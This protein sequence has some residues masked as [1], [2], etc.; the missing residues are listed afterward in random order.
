MLARTPP[1]LDVGAYGGGGQMFLTDILGAHIKHS[2][3]SSAYENLAHKNKKKKF[4]FMTSYH[5]TSQHLTN[6]PNL[7]FR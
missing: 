5:P 7:H 3:M 6:Q 4:I 2:K 1:G